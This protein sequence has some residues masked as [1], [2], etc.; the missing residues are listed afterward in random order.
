M[1]DTTKIVADAASCRGITISLPGGSGFQ[2]GTIGLKIYVSNYDPA[3][4]TTV[5]I[6][7]TGSC[8]GAVK[9]AYY[10]MTVQAG[11]N[12]LGLYGIASKSPV[13]FTGNARI[14]GVT[15]SHG[16]QHPEYGTVLSASYSTNQPVKMTGN[17]S[18]S[19]DVL[20]CNPQGNISE[21]GN[22]AI[23][24]HVIRNAPEPQ[25]PVVDI[26]TLK[27]YATNT[28]SGGGSGNLNLSNIIIPPNTNPN[29]SG[30]STVYGVVYV[31]SPNKVTFSGNTNF[32]G[33]IVC[34][35]PTVDDLNSNK[36]SFTGNLTVSSVANL[37]AGAQYDPIRSQAGTFLLAPGYNVS[38]TGN[39]HSVSGCMVASQFSFTGNAA[40]II[41]GG[42]C[43][44]RDSNFTL[45]GNASIGI[46]REDAVENPAGLTSSSLLKCVAGSYS[47]L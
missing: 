40:G 33:I 27:T 8:G 31:K 7:S 32:C 26:S 22:I 44:L 29:F 25:W 15:D 6:A 13:V 12:A 36:I 5:T 42:I 10:N 18:T 14:Y 19:S 4:Y 34:D 30:N 21:T 16:V 39:F 11:S 23:G 20:I 28:Y 41:S 9:T 43:N 37:P 24:G 1:V 38:F 45:T 46:N 2:A 35:T 17:C 47:E 3:T